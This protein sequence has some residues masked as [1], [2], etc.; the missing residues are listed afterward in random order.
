MGKIIGIDLGTSNSCVAIMEDGRSKVIENSGGMRTTPSVIAYQEDGEIIIGSPAKRQAPGNPK[1]TLFA[2]KRLIGRKFIEKE[3]QKE[4]GVVPFK[5]TATDNGDAWVTVRNQLLA[6]PQISAE[7]LR[8]MKKNAEDYLGETV[9]EAVIT[10]PAHFNDAQRQATKDAGRIAGLDVKRII[11]EPTAAAL[12][13]GLDKNDNQDRHIAVYDLGGGSFDVSIID[14]TVVNGEKQFEVLSTNG[15]TFLGGEDFDQLLVDYIIGEFMRTHAVDLTKDLGAVQRIKIAAERAKIELSTMRHTEINE[16]YIAMVGG[17]AVHLRQK[18]TRAELELLVD[19]LISATIEPCRI[20]LMDAKFK[21]SDIDD[22]LLIGG[23]TRMPLVQA[24]VEQFFGK[25]PCTNIDPDEAVAVGASIQAAV[26]AGDLHNLFLLDVTPLSL[27]IETSGGMTRNM[28]AKNTTI[29]TSV[30]QVFAT[31]NDNQTAMAVNI[32][33]GEHNR[34][35]GNQTLGKFVLEGIPAS[36][37]G[38]ARIEMLLDI[39]ANGIVHVGAKDNVTGKEKSMTNRANSGLTENEILQMVN[40]A[41]LNSES[42]KNMKELAG[43]RNQADD[44]IYWT[45]KALVEYDGEL[46]TSRK[47]EINRSISQLET[48][49]DQGIKGE[50]NVTLKALTTVAQKLYATMDTGVQ[51]KRMV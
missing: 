42:D 30:S 24:R 3:V 35:A 12:A 47:V 39:D 8:K 23:M 32:C 6:P 27:S 45:R 43:F 14:I 37:R 11:N 31:A 9:T 49:A 4:I 29:P 34:A 46:D 28:I 50:I 10:V 1:N 21:V 20:A 15:D 41:E 25:A 17:V 33:Q 2:M 44:L 13:F 16:P 19:K 38:I 18:L 51:K 36:S 22:I 7:L 48:A 40:D 5:I 26:L